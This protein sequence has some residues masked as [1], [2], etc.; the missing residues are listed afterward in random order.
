MYVNFRLQF[1]AAQN[2]VYLTLSKLSHMSTFR[3][4]IRVISVMKYLLDS[5]ISQ[6]GGADTSKASL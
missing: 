5:K 4:Q 2:D 3:F 1:S 6:I